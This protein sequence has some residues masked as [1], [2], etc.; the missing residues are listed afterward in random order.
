M[1]FSKLRGRMAEKGYS[2]R[3]MAKE[4][5]I[6]DMTFYQKMTGK[7]DWKLSEMY[8]IKVLLDI[9]DLEPYFFT[10]KLRHTKE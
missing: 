5:G 3:S 1:E 6:S 7:T 4:L 10:P 9:D 8:R 2:G